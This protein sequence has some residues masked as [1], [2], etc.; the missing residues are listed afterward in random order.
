MHELQLLGHWA[1]SHLASIR[2]FH[3]EWAIPPSLF[4]EITSRFGL[5]LI[6]LFAPLATIRFRGI[7]PSITIQ[8]QKR[9]MDSTP[10]GPQAFFMLSL[11]FL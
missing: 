5:P 9:L 4:Q 2:A 3:V 1:E 10:L 8:G 11:P 7:I 6:D